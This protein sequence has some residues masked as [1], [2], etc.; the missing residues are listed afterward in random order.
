MTKKR[1]VIADD[2][3]LIHAAIGHCLEDTSDFELVGS[4]VSGTQVAP[5]V[6][7]TTPDLV[8]LDLNM[9]VLD[10]LDCLAV[11][12][13]KFPHVKVVIFSGTED[14]ETIATALGAGATAYVCK[15]TNPQDLPSVFRVALDGTAY[16]APPAAVS[17]AA[18][19]EPAPESGLTEREVEILAAVA[20]GLSNREVGKELFLSDQTVKFHLHNI[21]GK[22]GVSNR[23]EASAAAHRLGL[24]D[25]ASTS[26]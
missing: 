9:P 10:G 18:E 6:A 7:R 25:P 4:A 8:L 3:P 19:R 16:Y 12:R 1:V 22:L 23:T 14:C 15:S 24:V 20:R 21:Y 11:L 26:G 17:S 13:E 5:L 2:H